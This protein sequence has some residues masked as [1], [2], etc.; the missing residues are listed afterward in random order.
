MTE[1]NSKIICPHCGQ[2]MSKWASPQD[3]TWGVE[4]QYICFNDECPYF[5][6]GWEWMLAQ[7][8]QHASYRHRYNPQT[9]E[10]GPLPVWSN[11]AL[12]N[13]IIE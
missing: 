11:E 1:K 3:S 10:S 12:K 7:F 5:I 13:S 6:K 8:N 4:F 9:G 2:K